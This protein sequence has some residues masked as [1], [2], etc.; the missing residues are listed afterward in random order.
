M[1]APLIIGGLVLASPV[2]L[3]PMAGYSD[4]PFRRAIR[5][6]GGLG[7]AFTEMIDPKSVL[8]G[9]GKKRQALLATSPDD[10]PLAWQIYGTDPA[11][12]ADAARWL[13]D[14]GARLIDINMGCPQKKISRRG[15]GAGLLKTPQEA[16]RLA[17]AVV[18]AVSIPVTAKLRTGWDTEDVVEDLAGALEATGLAAITIHGRTGQQ[19]FAGTANW[20]VIGRVVAKVRRIPV[21]GN[22]DITTAELAR[23]MLAKTGCAGIMVGRA[24]LNN[25]WIIREIQAALSGSSSV[26]PTRREHLDFMQ[27]HFDAMAAQH[28][29]LTGV[30]L[31][32]RWIPH[33]ARGLNLGRDKMIAWLQLRQADELRRNFQELGERIALRP[34]T[35]CPT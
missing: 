30:R 26:K 32:R 24:A 27:R 19:R 29:E 9:G 2:C 18:K 11:L 8:R 28:G 3:A 15:S 34:S 12:L 13:A 10:Q 33:Y 21:I 14:R 4:W 1:P 31:F 7:L 16:I 23:A 17:A 5:S 35:P 6:L 20:E 25:P 22:G